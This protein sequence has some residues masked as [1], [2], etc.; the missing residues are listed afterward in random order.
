MGIE[1]HAIM[2]AWIKSD[3]SL[4]PADIPPPG[5]KIFYKSR[6]EGRG[7]GIALV[8]LEDLIVLEYPLTMEFK[9]LEMVMYKIK[10]DSIMY[11]LV[12]VYRLPSASIIELCDKIAS[13]IKNNVVNLKG[14]LIMIGNFNIRIDKPGNP[15]TITFADFLKL[16]L[17]NDL[18][19]AIHQCQHTT[20]LVIIRETL[21]CIAEV[22][23]GFTLLD[24][25][26]ISAV[27]M[28]AKC[29]KTKTKVSSRKIK[30]ITLE[31][32]KC[33]L[34]EFNANF[35]SLDEPLTIWFMSTTPP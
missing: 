11:D 20:D 17:Q 8:C 7:G 35:V 31:E 6:T 23:K 22:R 5:Y 30:S 34:A 10:H 32:F 16:G 24:H 26:F 3:D 21:S 13:F 27:L 29:N 4:T 33:D 2:E 14:E 1:I 28:V 9:T 19:F 15:D 18:G 25:A 12:V